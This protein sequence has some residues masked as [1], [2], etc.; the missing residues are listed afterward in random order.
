MSQVPYW[1]PLCDKGMSKCSLPKSV[2]GIICKCTEFQI[3]AFHV[4]VHRSTAF[5]SGMQ[6]GGGFCAMASPN[7]ITGP[8]A[9]RPTLYHR[10]RRHSLTFPIPPQRARII[11]RFL[12]QFFDA[13]DY[14]ITYDMSVCN[15]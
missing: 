2:P 3:I 4:F 8:H 9:W 1:W 11:S 14:F 7:E 15:V 6:T 5:V 13:Y 10:H 12:P